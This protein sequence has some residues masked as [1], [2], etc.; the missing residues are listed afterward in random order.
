MPQAVLI[1]LKFG[2]VCFCG[3][4]KTGVTGEK[5]LEQGD[6]QQQIQLTYGT[7]WELYPGHI[8]WR[9]A[10]P[11]LHDPYFQIIQFPLEIFVF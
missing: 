8:G 2:E 7:R 9:R 11:P 10:I 1:E 4:K 3:R 5:P 6:N